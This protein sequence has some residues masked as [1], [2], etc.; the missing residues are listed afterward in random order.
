MKKILIDNT[1]ASTIISELIAG[2]SS[3]NRDRADFSDRTYNDPV[4]RT[5]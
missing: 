4:V 2:D 3:Q 1:A 5:V